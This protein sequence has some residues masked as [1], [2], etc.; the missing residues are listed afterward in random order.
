MLFQLLITAVLLLFD[1]ILYT[2]MD[3]IAQNA[4]SDYHVTGRHMLEA[5]IKGNGT[6]A[7]L[8]RTVFVRFMDNDHRLDVKG[9]N[10][11]K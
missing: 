8:M 3:L 6:I 9:S 11:G 4:E 10:L 5:K 7:N 1:E 2:V